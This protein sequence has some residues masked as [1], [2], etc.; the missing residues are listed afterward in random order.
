MRRLETVDIGYELT[1]GIKSGS[2][3]VPIVFINARG[4][5]QD[6]WDQVLPRLFLHTTVTYDRPG[7]GR[8][9]PLPSSLADTP[10]SFGI[11][12]DELHSLLDKLA[13]GSPRVVVGHSIGG[14]IATTYAARYDAH[15]AGLVLVDSTTEHHL[16]NSR[17]P[18]REGGDD[19][20]SS[21][22]DIP[23]SI[24][25][26]DTAV[27]PSVPAA[28]VASAAGRWTR[29]PASAAAEYGSLSL[30]ELDQ[31]WQDGQRQLADKLDALLV[32]ADWA[33]HHVPT[34]QPELVAASISA[35][36]S[37]VRDHLPVAIPPAQLRY[38]GG[39]CPA[40]GGR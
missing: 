4:T 11:L 5:E 3:S 30:E 38:A 18:A 12:A 17:W 9:A 32:V 31:Q 28:V 36:V 7:I 15:T 21:I 25:E 13:I 23:A 22:I 14:L 2:G 8:S 24:A 37:A 16:K 20:G 34:D 40:P 26:L 35:V 27:W 6:Q 19:F 10:R 39:S 33:G 1:A 29:L